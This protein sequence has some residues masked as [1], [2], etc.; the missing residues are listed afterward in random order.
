MKGLKKFLAVS[1]AAFA[2]YSLPAC[3]SELQKPAFYEVDRGEGYRLE[4][5]IKES[6]VRMYDKDGKLVA[7]KLYKKKLPI[8]EFYD[9][10]GKIFAEAM[11]DSE[12]ITLKGRDKPV[13]TYGDLTVFEEDGWS[14]APL[15]K[16]LVDTMLEGH[17]GQFL[18]GKSHDRWYE[19]E[20]MFTSFL[21]GEQALEAK[22]NKEF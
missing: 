7:K 5:R 22:Y 20:K 12:I 13:E 17:G 8:Y 4:R 6:E 1:L 9:N 18:D 2:L 11:L 15:W 3:K 16:N 14:S 10:K 19:A 21:K